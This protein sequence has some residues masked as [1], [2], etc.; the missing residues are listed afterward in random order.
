MM[1]KC[2]ITGGTI[3]SIIIVTTAGETVQINGKRINP[4]ADGLVDIRRA[5]KR[6]L[7]AA[8]KIK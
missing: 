3:G 2:T 4:I 5:A 6:A 7:K 8:N 1:E